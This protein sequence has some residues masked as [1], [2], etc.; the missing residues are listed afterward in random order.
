MLVALSEKKVWGK[1]FYASPAAIDQ[2]GNNGSLVGFSTVIKKKFI[3]WQ[4]YWRRNQDE[5][6]F[7]R[8]NPSIYRNL[9]ISNKIAAELNGSYTSNIGVTGFGIETAK[10]FLSVIIL[11]IIT[12]F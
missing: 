12:V 8:K 6:V 10:V 1:W 7:I 5:Y 11:E 3:C 2:W 9:H 4:V